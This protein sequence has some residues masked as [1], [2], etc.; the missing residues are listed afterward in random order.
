M[1]GNP[2][3]A[4]L[5]PQPGL[6]KAKSSRTRIL[7]YSSNRSSSSR[8]L[9]CKATARCIICQRKIKKKKEELRSRP[10]YSLRG[11]NRAARDE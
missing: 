2:S 8:F 10:R 1:V 11:L 9:M 3:K 5:P 7:P 6:V 4:K